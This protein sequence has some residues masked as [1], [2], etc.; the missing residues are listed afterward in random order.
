MRL[1][2]CSPEGCCTTLT[3]DSWGGA[4]FDQEERLGTY[5]KYLEMADGRFTYQQE[6]GDQY[7]YYMEVRVNFLTTRRDF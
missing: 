1:F 7:L 3:L 5:A 2:L 6:G 4:S